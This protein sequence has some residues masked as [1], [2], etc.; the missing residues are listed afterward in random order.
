MRVAN[1]RHEARNGPRDAVFKETLALRAWAA[2]NVPMI[3]YVRPKVTHVDD[4]GVTICIPLTRRTKNHLR[5]MYFGALQVGADLAAGFMALR[6]AKGPISFVFKDADA[7]FVR[8]AEADVEF[9][10]RDGPAIRQTVDEALRTGKRTEVPV[11][12][13]A[14]AAGEVVAQFTLTLSLKAQ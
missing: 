4:D 2:K 5:S 9:A 7:K 6:H 10:C 1:P 12:V 3:G 13:E 8:R 14:T 11:H